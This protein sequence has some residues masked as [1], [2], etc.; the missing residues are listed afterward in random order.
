MCG[1][2][3]PTVGGVGGLYRGPGVHDG[4]VTRSKEKYSVL[5]LSR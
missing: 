3:T 2:E 4:R 5:S 1:P